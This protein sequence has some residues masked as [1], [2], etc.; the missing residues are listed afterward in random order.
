MLFSASNVGMWEALVQDLFLARKRKVE[1]PKKEGRG[2][3]GISV[4]FLANCVLL[5]VA[6]LC[7]VI[8]GWGS[9][10]TEWL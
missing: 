2:G 1:D 10:T 4:C 9:I 8:V 6:M 7:A 3:G 5:Y